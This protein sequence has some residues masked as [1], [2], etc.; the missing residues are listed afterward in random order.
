MGRMIAHNARMRLPMPRIA[1]LCLGAALALS[2]ACHR[3]GVSSTTTTTT[4]T[5]A[6]QPGQAQE[7]AQTA[8]I[9][10]ITYE[11]TGGIA[12]F[13]LRLHIDRE[14]MAKVYDR[15]NPVR[16]GQLSA[17]DWQDVQRLVDAAELPALARTYGRD[18]AVVD[19]MREVV[20]VESGDK[21][22]QVAAV[23]DPSEQP[24]QGFVELTRRL[25]EL[26]NTLPPD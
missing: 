15:G 5:E 6:T 19:A 2:L 18:G 3:S 17:Q 25:M 7:P 23:T 14:G 11:L 24:P 20:T 1:V 9:P 16:G 13:Q 8:A 12:G 10:E 26:T 22:V 4:T 21:F